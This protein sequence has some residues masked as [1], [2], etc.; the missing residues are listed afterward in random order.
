MKR[1]QGPMA[2]H[3]M[4]Q[5]THYGNPRKTEKT[6]SLSEEN[7]PEHPKSEERKVHTN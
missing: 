5:C 2:P 4:G 3:Q 7:I 6:E 1:E